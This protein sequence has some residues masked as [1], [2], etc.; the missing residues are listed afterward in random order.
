MS[1]GSALET[2]TSNKPSFSK[3]RLSFLSACWFAATIV[4]GCHPALAQQSPTPDQSPPPTGGSAVLPIPQ[5]QF[6]GV[7][8]RK[9]SDSTPDFP[10]AVTAPKG[11]PNVLLIMTDDT[12]FGAASTFGGPIPTPT[13][14]RLATSG[15]RYNEFHTTALCS[16]TRAALLT[17]RNHQSVGMGNI[18]EFA[19]G[20]P[21]YT[22][23]MPK[24]AGTIGNI[25]VDNGYN[26]AWFGKH[27]LVP[28]W[29]QGPGGPFDQWAGGLGFEYFYGFLGGDTDQFHPALFENTTPVLP[30]FG[31]PNYIL[32]H[33]L[34]DRTINWIRTQHAAAPEKPFLVCISHPATATL[35]TRLP[36]TG[37]PSSKASST[38]AGTKCARRRWRGK[39]G[40]GSFRPVLF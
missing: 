32:I 30:P 24:S 38:R 21:G 29:M 15:L 18:T 34:A 7:I 5:P 27:H 37:S 9:A 1:T 12:G 25:L 6:R 2:P 40:S 4:A 3:H 16:P 10:K 39:S 14:D 22:S 28:E 33:D 13:L 23:I 35:R 31:D 20:Y 11:A 8:G 26:T 19:T 17:G 36:K